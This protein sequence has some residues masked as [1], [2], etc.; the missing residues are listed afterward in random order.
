VRKN[1]MRGSGVNR[2]RSKKIRGEK[3]A[4]GEWNGHLGSPLSSLMDSLAFGVARATH[5]GNILY[6]NSY[7]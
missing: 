3:G 4:P 6:T 5:N 1:S 2:A 7:F